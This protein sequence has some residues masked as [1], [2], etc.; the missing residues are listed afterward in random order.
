MTGGKK[1]EAGP[2]TDCGG[3]NP[4]ISEAIKLMCPHQLEFLEHARRLR[5]SVTVDRRLPASIIC[6][7]CD[8]QVW[9]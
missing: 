7:E 9:L 2:I 5:V 8:R 1:P 6:R 3:G 4:D